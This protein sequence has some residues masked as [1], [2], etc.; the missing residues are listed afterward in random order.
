MSIRDSEEITQSEI[1]RMIDAE[2]DA[3]PDLLAGPDVDGLRAAF[4]AD[5]DWCSRHV[6]DPTV[7]ECMAVI[8]GA[9]AVAALILA[10]LAVAG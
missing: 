8:A 10:V 5:R 7:R 3:H 6:V 2:Q 4:N 9:I 1:H